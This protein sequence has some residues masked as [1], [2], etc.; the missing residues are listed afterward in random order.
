[1]YQRVQK[2]FEVQELFVLKITIKEQLLNV[3]CKFQHNNGICKSIIYE[4][5]VTCIAYHDK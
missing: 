4:H 5:L 2:S 3:D 1:M